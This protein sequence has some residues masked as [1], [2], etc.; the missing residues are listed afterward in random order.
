LSY[1][2]ATL[3][4]MRCG[5]WWHAQVRVRDAKSQERREGAEDCKCTFH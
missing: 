5:S 1:F 2:G 4:V 3:H